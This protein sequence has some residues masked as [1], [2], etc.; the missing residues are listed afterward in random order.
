MTKTTDA[1]HLITA[2]VLSMRSAAEDRAEIISQT[3]FGQAVTVLDNS[4]VTYAKIG[5]SDGYEGWVLKSH[6]VE[7]SAIADLMSVAGYSIGTVTST[8]APVYR[9]PG[10]PQSQISVLSMGSLVRIKYN[11]GGFVSIAWAAEAQGLIGS[12][13]V[14]TAHVAW[15]APS[16]S[17]SSTSID[18]VSQAR[19]LLGTPYLWG[20][21]SSFGIDCSGLT[22]LAFRMCGVMLPRDAYLQAACD[23]SGGL[24]E[25]NSKAAA[26][27]ISNGDLVFFI[28]NQDPLK[29]GITHVGIAINCREF[30]HSS[31][32]FGVHVHAFV[33]PVIEQQ[34]KFAG[35]IS[36]SELL[37][38]R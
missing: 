16:L 10:S 14:E 31:S 25:L 27:E 21:G 35:L 33:D 23:I 26:T 30:I 1:T 3:L 7:L 36:T 29:R 18:L 4:G 13:Y 38:C 34:Y 37:N 12:A 5:T 11:N 28:G 2:N 9:E 20:G 22:Q 6:L 24:R 17:L 19:K 15:Q 32:R 8:F